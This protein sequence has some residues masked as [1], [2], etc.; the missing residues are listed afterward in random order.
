ML[1][2]NNFQ[3]SCH[4]CVMF[5]LFYWDCFLL[6][7]KYFQIVWKK[8]KSASFVGSLAIYP[9][10]NYNLQNM[11]QNSIHEN[12]TRIL[13][14]TSSSRRNFMTFW[15]NGLAQS[16]TIDRPRPSLYLNLYFASGSILFLLKDK[17][18]WSSEPCY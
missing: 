6:I 8:Y 7:W 17:G 18:H 11:H 5:S 10:Y 4:F 16:L 3:R 1:G 15:W 12:W 2:F 9:G 13:L 14:S